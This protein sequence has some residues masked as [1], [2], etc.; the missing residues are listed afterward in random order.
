MEKFLVCRDEVVAGKNAF[1]DARVGQNV[2][3]GFPAGIVFKRCLALSSPSLQSALTKKYPPGFKTRA[4]S[5]K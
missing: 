2:G 4:V 1:T 3:V 5:D